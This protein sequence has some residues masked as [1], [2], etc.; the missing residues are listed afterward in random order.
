MNCNSALDHPVRLYCKPCRQSRQGH[1]DLCYCLSADWRPL[2]YL[3][4]HGQRYA[5][6]RKSVTQ[7]RRS[8]LPD[9]TVVIISVLRQSEKRYLLVRGPEKTVV[10]FGCCHSH[11]VGWLRVVEAKPAD[12]L[13]DS[14]F[15]GAMDHLCWLNRRMEFSLQTVALVRSVRSCLPQCD[16][17]H[18]LVSWVCFQK[19]LCS[20]CSNIAERATASSLDQWDTACRCMEAWLWLA[21]QQICAVTIGQGRRLH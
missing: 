15:V 8:L 1:N 7:Y 5:T 10:C 12:R 11:I 4:S 14:S 18:S 16:L 2:P 6:F 21:L 9:L 17:W 20:G 3:E 19:I 13:E